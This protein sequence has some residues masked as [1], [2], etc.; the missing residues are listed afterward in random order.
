MSQVVTEL[1]IDADTAGADQYSQAMD[2]VADSAGK[3]LSSLQSVG[4]AIA[5]VSVSAVGAIAG[6]RGFVDYVGQQTQSL[7]DLEDHAT[8]AGVSVREFQEDLFAARSKGLAEK[9]FVSGFDRIAS[10]IQQASQQATEFSKLF[11]AN[12]L[13]IRQSN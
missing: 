8:L 1:T 4:L 5:G 6:L 2:R 12:G 9:D 3:G 7:V 13:S 11:D 10:D